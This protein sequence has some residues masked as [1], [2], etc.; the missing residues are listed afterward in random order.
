MAD[1]DRPTYRPLYSKEPRA[2]EELIVKPLVTKRRSLSPDY[3]P[4]VAP[5]RQKHKAGRRSPNGGDSDDRKTGA[6]SLEEEG[7]L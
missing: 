4:P 2:N 7:L 3:A 1:Y 6:W 5:K